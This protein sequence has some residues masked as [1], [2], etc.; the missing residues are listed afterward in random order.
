[1]PARRQSSFADVQAQPHS[2]PDKY[3]TYGGRSRFLE[4]WYGDAPEKPGIL[5]IHGG[6]WLS[7]YGLDHVRPLCTA[8]NQL[9][10]E[11]WSLEYR[12]VGETGGGWPGSFEDI[13]AG[14]SLAAERVSSLI[15]MGH[16]AGGHMALWAA[17]QEQVPGIRA[18]VGL[19]AISDLVTYAGGTSSCEQ[20]TVSLLGGSPGAQPARYQAAS[21]LL[22]P[23]QTPTVLVHGTGDTIVS[24]L[25]SETFAREKGA[26]YIA[27]DG[28]GHF[29]LV[30]PA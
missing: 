12:R 11:T 16:S 8:I 29:D 9:G 4:G 15:V 6:C 28:L 27:I 20:A 1:M 14:V 30:N 22:L 26:R 19:A 21:P 24:P 3:L 2:V 18:C 23:S 17:A 7:E 25:Q 5:M 10:F 13:L